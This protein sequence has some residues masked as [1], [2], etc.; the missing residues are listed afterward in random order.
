[1]LDLHVQTHFVKASRHQQGKHKSKQQSDGSELS[2]RLFWF[3]TFISASSLPAGGA[4]ES[5]LPGQLPLWSVWPVVWSCPCHLP[6][7]LIHTIT[8]TQ[9][10]LTDSWTKADTDLNNSTHARTLAHTHTHT[11]TSL[12]CIYLP[13]EG[14]CATLYVKRRMYEPVRN[15]HVP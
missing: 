2:T 8:H 11:H 12:L 7:D 1:M 6:I 5:V 9:S 4:R 10:R 14:R 3:K 15:S 13:P